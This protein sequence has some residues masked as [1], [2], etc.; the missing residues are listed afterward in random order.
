MEVL[1]GVVLCEMLGS[2]LSVETHIGHDHANC[3]RER[4]LNPK[5]VPMLL[6]SEFVSPGSARCL[7][8]NPT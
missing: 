5:K 1:E 8:M 4:D 2:A 7:E 6:M 3:Q